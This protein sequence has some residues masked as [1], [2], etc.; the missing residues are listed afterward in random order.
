MACIAY[1]RVSKK[2]GRQTV[3]NQ[4]P[5]VEALAAARGLAIDEVFEDREGA[6][7]RI[8]WGSPRHLRAAGN[9]G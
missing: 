4:R 7:R 1:L 8:R 6:A 2:D 5:D 9:F 3:E